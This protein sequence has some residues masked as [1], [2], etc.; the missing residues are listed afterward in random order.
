MAVRPIKISVIADADK[1]R[2]ELAS[3]GNALKTGLTVAA[4]A[5]AAGVVAVL[6]S[7]V[8]AAS[9]AQ[10]SIGATQAIYGRYADSVI[11]K[12]TEAADAV[13][14]SANAYRESSNLLGALFKN[15]GVELSKLSIK[16]DEHLKLA[17]DLSAM[18][19][20]TVTDSVD[21]LT[22]AYKGEF[23]QLEKYGVS[24]KQDTINTKANEVAKRKYG[25]ELKELSPKQQSLAKQL[26]TQKL[27]FKQTADATGTFGK[28]SNTL[29]GQQQRLGAELDNVKAE[30][31][32]AL[33]PVL[34]DLAKWARREV[35]PAFQDFAKWLSK[36]EDE[37]KSTAREIGNGLLPVLKT[38]GDVVAD[39]VRFFVGL[40]G[41]VKEMGVQV[42]IAALVL[43]RLAAGLGLVQARATAAGLSMVTFGQ[44]LAQNRAAMTYA[45]GAYGKAAAAL[46]GFGGAARTVAGVGGLLLLTQASK[47]SNEATGALMTT[48]GAAGVGFM[49]AGPWGALAGGVAGAGK[50][51]WDTSKAMEAAKQEAVKLNG[52]IASGTAAR[53]Q[54]EA[55]DYLNWALTLNNA[56]KLTLDTIKRLKDAI[57]TGGPDQSLLVSLSSEMK[58]LGLNSNTVTKAMTGN[59]GA[60]REVALAM[61]EAD[62][63]KGGTLEL[64]EAMKALKT[65]ARGITS[66]APHVQSFMIG[67]SKNRGGLTAVQQDLARMNRE[68]RSLRETVREPIRTLFRTN[69]PDTTIEIAK[70]AKQYKLTPGE[71]TTIIELTNVGTTQKHITALIRQMKGLPPEAKKE[72]AKAGKALSDGVGT[73]PKPN[74]AGFK[75][76]LNGQINTLVGSARTGGDRV[77]SNLGSGM[78]AGLGRWISP[79]AARS[80][81]MV[82]AA[83]K[84]AQTAG[85]I[86]SPSKKTTYLGS[87]LGEGLVVGLRASQPKARTAGQQ[88][89]D[90]VRAGVVKGSAGVEAALAK[91]TAQIEKSITGKNQ[92]KR[93]KALLDRYKAQFK[94]LRDNAKAQD[95]VTAK[96]ETARDK[97]KELTDQYKDYAAAIKSSIVTTGDVTQLGRNDDGTVSLSNLLTELKNKVVAA[98]RFAVLIRDLSAKGLSQTAIQQ[99]L[100]AGPE[101]ALA[102]AEAIA[103]GGAASITEINALQAQLAATGSQLGN[104]MAGT[105]Y[106]AGVKAAQGIVK[107]LEAEAKTLDAA[108]VRLANSLVAAVKKALGIRSPSRVFMGL[109]DQVTKGLAI[110]VDDTYIKRT[111]AT[112]AAALQ[113]GFGTPALD[114]YAAGAG[115][116]ASASPVRVEVRLTADQVSQVQRGK[117]A[118]IDIDAAR[119]VGARQMAVTVW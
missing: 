48:L 87:M 45:T 33:L 22:A 91:I 78:Y 46:H 1:A 75:A 55:K 51:L 44:R 106:G 30:I 17:A 79:L 118:L 61:V 83:I 12:S 99:M 27:L 70:V 72:G 96:L 86:Q 81:G 26:A 62:R 3:V 119:S 56:G 114:A 9:D 21:A 112:A 73:A 71:I 60:L 85:Q 39:V 31:G 63:A 16:T 95:K 7:S 15:Q 104:A 4:A 59:A 65:N 94:A 84:S 57:N 36:N 67:W 103:S 24:L 5:G 77:G 19:G 10:Q 13:G 93:E 42:G 38:T 76:S 28:E 64:N 11:K 66:L 107:G 40:P 68:T 92:A 69:A 100:D 8:S 14:L 82:S 58:T 20:G 101:A 29:A 116:G 50:A 108:A 74:L 105:Y 102:T 110:G 115:R 23:N 2:K 41:P 98:Q 80:A 34:T 88:L 43:P 111:G 52:A 49:L 54:K 109:G 25:K 90:A 117:A 113:K 97:L 6:K 35:V 47:Q 18:Y 53:L 32:S 89:V 37:I